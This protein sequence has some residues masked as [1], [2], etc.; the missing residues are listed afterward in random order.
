MGREQKVM[1]ALLIAFLCCVYAEAQ[2]PQKRISLE[3]K[4]ERL[5]TV[6]NKIGDAT[7]YKM[8]FSNE[9][10]QNYGINGSIKKKTVSEALNIVI[11]EKP[12]T[13]SIG[14][15]F[16]TIAMKAEAKSVQTSDKGCVL[17]GLVVDKEGFPLPGVNIY[18]KE[19]KKGTVTGLDG[20]YSLKVNNS[21]SYVV[22][23][24]YIG[25]DSQSQTVKVANTEEKDLGTLVLREDQLELNE[26][27]VTGYQN[28]TR[29]EMAGSVARLSSEDIMNPSAYS[30]DQM[31]AGQVA[32]MSVIQSSGSPTAA[33]KIRIRGTSSILGNKSPLWVLDGIILEENV[34]VDYAD[35]TGDDAEYLIGNAISGVNPNDIESITILKDASATAIYGTRAANGVI[36]VS[37]K[38][39]KQGKPRI[40]YSG[41]LTV[42]ERERYGK[43]NQM[44]AAERI[45]FSKEILEV[46]NLHYPRNKQDMV[47]GYE[48]YYNQWKS[49]SI[50]EEEFNAEINN[51][52]TRDTDW[53]DVLF[54]NSF[55]QNHS[56]SLDG[57]DDRTRYYTSVGISNIQGTAREEQT[58]RYTMNAKL[59]SYLTK[60]IFLGFNLIGTISDSDGYYSGLSPRKWAF[61]TARTIP[62]YKN[63]GSSFFFEPF[64]SYGKGVDK[65]TRNYLN[66]LDETG[67]K[68]K[69]SGVT[70]SG[71]FDWKFWDGFKY[72]MFAS[73][74]KNINKKS[75]WATD[76]SHVVAGIRKYSSNLEVLP[77]GVNWENSPL[78]QGGLLSRAESEST[79]WNVRNEI[80]YNKAFKNEHVVSVLAVSEVRSAHSEGFNGLYYGYLPDRG[81]TIA[82]AYSD[83]YLESLS[84]GKIA[85]P[86]MSDATYNTVSWRGI[87]S[88]SF[89]DRYNLNANVSMDGSNQFGANPKYRFL[90]I[91]SVSGKWTLSEEPFMK[92]LQESTL[93]YLALRASYGIQG[94][95]NTGTSPDLVLRIG[96]IDN[97]SGL[98]TSTVAYW[99]N[100]DLRWEKTTSYNLGL[101]FSVLQDWLSGTVDFYQKKGTDMILTK[102]FSAVN[103]LSLYK[104]NAGNI[105]NTGIE[106]AV[107]GSLVRNKDW[108]AYIQLTYSC[109]TNK[110]TRVNEESQVTISERI[111]GNGLLV[112]ESIGT[113]YSYD[114]A[115]LDHETGLP[116]FRDKS[117]SASSIIDGKEVPN[118][119]INEN[120]V[121]VVKSGVTIPPHTGGFNFG[122]RYRN[123]RLSGTFTYSFGAVGRLPSIYG[124]NTTKVFDPEFNVPRDLINRW[125][126]PG[127]EAY[128]EVPVLYDDYTYNALPLRDTGNGTKRYGVDLYDLSTARICSTDNFR[129]SNLSLLY[130][131]PKKWLSKYKIS[132][133]SFNATVSNLFLIAS[134]RW[135]GSDPELGISATSA[136]TRTYSLSLNIGF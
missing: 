133:C 124:S 61:E 93:P 86:S 82:P 13:Y 54:R 126:Q 62:C 34:N 51:M 6:L 81:L 21:T 110:L 1:G 7:G 18:V 9:D 103:G 10:V 19:L 35:L 12:F 30:I 129:M 132:N 107:K 37:T 108:D 78:S 96:S 109:N 53:F 79:T 56:I 63:D 128:T 75:N 118:Y 85:S 23:Y 106:T 71:T 130:N 115:G 112:G 136:L 64:E 49:K 121:N 60:K 119:T 101:D 39:G 29:R 98:A 91:W 26:I 40:S 41:S 43:L 95:S 117:G 50:T 55:S 125:K 47:L 3:F 114:F 4:N 83:A 92:S 70:A 59:E 131:V 5:S 16:I 57:G 99:P 74:V 11:G 42:N 15:R 38:K 80:S 22:T 116:I 97:Y 69:T 88:Y 46:G 14:S 104:I 120:D 89:R 123:W 48:Y 31:L 32:G 20:K 67:A 94:N 113:I 72:R 105:E 17:I 122:L 65:L 77:G 66:E 76:M 134:K 111:S 127:D 102:N 135:N 68:N 2:S 28:L 90:P 8:I 84:K 44:N 33:P 25:M 24:S 27:I 45:Q 87:V 73:F 52:A 36:V 58:R 100:A